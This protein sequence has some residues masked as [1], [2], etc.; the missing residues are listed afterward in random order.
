MFVENGFFLK[1]SSSETVPIPTTFGILG[2]DLFIKPY[3]D[4]DELFFIKVYL[5]P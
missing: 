5:I 3:Y 4:C 1:T 2:G